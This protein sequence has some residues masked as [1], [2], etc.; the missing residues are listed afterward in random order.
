MTSLV[1]WGNERHII[2]IEDTG[3]RVLH[4]SVYT[5]I[6]MY[7]SGPQRPALAPRPLKIYC[8]YTHIYICVY[9][10]IY[11]YTYNS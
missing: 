6:C 2:V 5:Y 11:M 10:Y 8:A 9:I 7:K 3:I 4:N 1:Y